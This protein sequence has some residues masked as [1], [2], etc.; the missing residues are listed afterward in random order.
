MTWLP[1]LRT[2]PSPLTANSR[3]QRCRVVSP[4][5]SRAATPRARALAKT[6]SSWISRALRRSSGLVSLPRPLPSRPGSFLPSTAAP[7]PPHGPSPCGAALAAA[8]LSPFDPPGAA[9][10]APS[11]RPSSA[12]AWRWH[13]V[14]PARSAFGRG[15]SR[16]P[17][18][19]HLLREKSPLAAVAAE[20]GGIEP[21]ALHHHC[22]LISSAP[23][24][25][26]LLG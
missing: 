19:A 26:F 22:E 12:P 3:R 1:F 18:A 2:V 11:V 5:P 9:S 17:P 13:L 25:W 23:A 7:L 16:L 10:G 20:L 24:L 4:T 8:V 15:G 6:A 21:S 14:P